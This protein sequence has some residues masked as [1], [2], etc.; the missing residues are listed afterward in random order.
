M[1]KLKVDEVSRQ[2]EALLRENPELDTDEIL[3]ADMID[4]ETDTI[5]IMRELERNRA[6]ALANAEAL[7]ATIE[8]NKNRMA[9]FRRQEMLIRTMMF[10]LL[11]AGQ[12]RKLVLP[13]ATLS[14]ATAPARVVI[15]NEDQLPDDYWRIKREPD[16]ERIK[17]ALIT[18]AVVPG[19]ELSNSPDYLR[20]SVG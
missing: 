17:L 4:G 7:A 6:E 2:V 20:I 11:Q 18:A 1:L 14:I 13:E 12:L 5:A 3:R 16:K 15:T 10:R 19:A 9:R 8:Q